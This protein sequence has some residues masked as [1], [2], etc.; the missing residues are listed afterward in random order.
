[1]TCLVSL[2][3]SIKQQDHQVVGQ[4]AKTYALTCTCGSCAGA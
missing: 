2:L 4:D 3:Q 1:M